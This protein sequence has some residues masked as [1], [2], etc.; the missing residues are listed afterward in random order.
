M[1]DERLEQEDDGQ[2]LDALAVPLQW[3]PRPIRLISQNN[4]SLRKKVPR[5]ERNEAQIDAARTISG[6]YASCARQGRC[7]LRKPR[8]GPQELSV[9]KIEDPLNL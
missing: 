6:S 8:I 1:L 3:Q 7:D 5:F 9:E 2:A 4:F